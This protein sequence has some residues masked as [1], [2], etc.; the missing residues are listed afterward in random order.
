MTVDELLDQFVKENEDQVKQF[1]VKNKNSYSVKRSNQGVA[2]SIDKIFSKIEV[3]GSLNHAQ[4]VLQKVKKQ[5]SKSVLNK[6]VPSIKDN[7]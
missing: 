6:S 5:M 7:G 4:R 3:D 1:C 2:S